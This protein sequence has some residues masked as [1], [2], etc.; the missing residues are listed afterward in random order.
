MGNMKKGY[1]I[2]ENGMIV[3]CQLDL[4]DKNILGSFKKTAD[5][6]GIECLHDAKIVN[7]TPDDS[8]YKNIKEG[9]LGKIVTDELPVDYHLYDLKTTL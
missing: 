3:N 6:C 2:F 4:E 7:F 9:T 5:Q 1:V 8:G